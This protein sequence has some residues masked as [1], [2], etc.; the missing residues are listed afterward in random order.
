VI[1]HYY[2]LDTKFK[3]FVIIQKN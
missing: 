3:R 1:S 2:N